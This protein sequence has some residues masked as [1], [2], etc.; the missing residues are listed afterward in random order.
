MPLVIVS[1][2]HPYCVRLTEHLILISSKRIFLI[3][4]NQAGSRSLHIPQGA[5]LEAYPTDGGTTYCNDEFDVIA[6][7]RLNVCTHI[8]LCKE[9]DFTTSEMIEYGQFHTVLADL[10]P[11]P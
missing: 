3:V 5:V 1:S 8:S 10:N 6:P 9:T 2:W 11:S 4:F 7:L